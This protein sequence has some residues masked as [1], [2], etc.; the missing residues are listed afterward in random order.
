MIVGH[1]RVREWE[2]VVAG[3]GHASG[4]RDLNNR[5]AHDRHLARCLPKNANTLFQPSSACSTPIQWPVVVE[6]A[7]AGAVVAIELVSLAVLF[8]LRL[9]LIDLLRARRAILISE[10]AEQRTGEIL[11]QLDRRDVGVLALSS[12]LAITTRPPHRSTQASMSFLLQ[13]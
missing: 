8:E 3:L 6:D 1:Y 11:G 10:D 9:V 5:C 12:S 2:P 7:V 13:A 4:R